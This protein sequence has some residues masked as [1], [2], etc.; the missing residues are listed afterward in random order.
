VYGTK[1]LSFFPLRDR[2][3]AFCYDVIGEDI[4]FEELFFVVHLMPT[5]SHGN[6][7]ASVESWLFC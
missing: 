7:T 3:V 2:L 4:E 5:L 1:F 6:A